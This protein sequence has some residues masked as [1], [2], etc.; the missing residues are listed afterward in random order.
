MR[1]AHFGGVENT[2]GVHYIISAGFAPWDIG[3]IFLGEKS[4]PF[5]VHSDGVFIIGYIAAK[6]PVDGVVLQHVRH[7]VGGHERV[8]DADKFQTG[9][10]KTRA[11]NQAAYTAESVDTDF[12][13]HY[14]AS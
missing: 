14:T 2:G 4:D 7:I 11:E 3:R 12:D 8:V 6:T 10:V 1:P 5:A 13:T 9:I